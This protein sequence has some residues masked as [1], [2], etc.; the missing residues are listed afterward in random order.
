MPGY[1]YLTVLFFLFT[2]T[3]F[4]Q[5]KPAT[6]WGIR[7]SG[8]VNAQMFYDTRRLIESREGMVSLL[9]LP[10]NK[11]KAGND[12]NAHSSFNQLAMTSRLR[13]EISGPR[14]LG[15]STSGVIEGD[16]TGQSNLDNNGF[17]L[18]E[19]W[20]KL[21]WKSRSLLAGLYWHPLYT[22]EVR[23]S[24]IGLNTGAPFHP[25]S[26]H[27]QLR[28]EQNTGILKIIAVAAS[29]RDYAS[30]GP[31]GPSPVYL[32]NAV[33]PNLDLQFQLRPGKHIIGWGLDYKMLMPRLKVDLPAGTEYK[34]DEKVHSFAAIVF[35]RIEFTPF[36]IQTGT[37]AGQNLTEHIMA[38]GYVEHTLD[39]VNHR[40]TYKPT[41]QISS[42]ID[43]SGKGKK[44]RPAIFAGYTKNLGY[45]GSS[46]GRFFGNFEDLAYAYRIAPRLQVYSGKLM[47]AIELEY[48]AA[49]W[50]EPD[51]MGKFDNTSE[52]CNY[53]IL[54]G[55]FY[56]F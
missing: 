28:F 9:P 36:I 35:A 3:A 21:E 1:R 56:F 16:F 12:I 20:V 54:F 34:T 4:S 53:R 15:A 8:F 55:V 22:P 17:R 40:I 33:L 43:I 26:R 46:E 27:N 14:A 25:F 52:T 18:R 31:E 44:I 51:N 7:F 19:A 13:G 6:G 47:L 5:E 48:T 2:L 30:N 42:W 29:Q 37:V 39:T 11:D 24:T 49:A 32:R 45:A 10:V 41:N 50:G 38:G 23:P